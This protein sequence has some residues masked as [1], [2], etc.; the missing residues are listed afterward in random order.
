MKVS[1]Y[2]D[3]MMSK[4]NQMDFGMFVVFVIFFINR[5]YDTQSMIPSTD[6]KNSYIIAPEH[7]I[8][9]AL[10]IVIIMQIVFKIHFFMIINEK[11]GMFVEL[12]ITCLVDIIP[13]AVFLLIWICTFTILYTVLG[14]NNELAG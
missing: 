7:V 10:N 14:S 5:F 11:F 8:L 3:Y 2:K 9:M 1:G 12:F 13:F 6:S 4:T